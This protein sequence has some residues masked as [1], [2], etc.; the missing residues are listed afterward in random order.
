MIL[1]ATNF[2]GKHAKTAFCTCCSSGDRNAP[3]KRSRGAEGSTNLRFDP[4]IRANKYWSSCINMIFLF[5]YKKYSNVHSYNLLLGKLTHMKRKVVSD[6]SLIY[7][8]LD[9]DQGQVSNYVVSALIQSLLE[10]TLNWKNID[11]E[12]TEKTVWEK[13]TCL[14]SEAVVLPPVR[15]ICHPS[16]IMGRVSSLARGFI[17][18]QETMKASSRKVL[19]CSIWSSLPHHWVWVAMWTGGSAKKV[20][21]FRR[22]LRKAAKL[23]WRGAS[24]KGAT[25]RTGIS[26]SPKCWDQQDDTLLSWSCFSNFIPT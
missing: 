19:T 15:K 3:F 4:I 5:S 11:V 21:T 2:K 24:V 9:R 16:E 25:E 17:F 10:I 8:Y 1:N 22:V 18:W 7:I 23:R 6:H 12:A 13:Q 26:A 14:I 20:L